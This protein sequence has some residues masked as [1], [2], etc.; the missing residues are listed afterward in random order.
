MEVEQRATTKIGED[1][2]DVWKCVFKFVANT[3][4]PEKF[5]ILQL[6]WCLSIFLHCWC[7]ANDAHEVSPFAMECDDD[8][9]ML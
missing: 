8:Q 5:V 1:F 3:C 4:N 9:Y 2:L 6:L 7:D